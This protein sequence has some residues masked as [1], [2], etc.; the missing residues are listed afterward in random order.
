MRICFYCH[1]SDSNLLDL[2]EFYKLDIDALKKLDEKLVIATRYKDIDWSCDIL[3]IWWWSY[4]LY[5]ILRGRF[6]H[7]MK[8]V[9]TGTFN[10][11]TLNYS[12]DYFHRPLWQKVLLKMA[13][14]FSCMNIMVSKN[15]YDMM[16][17]DWKYDNFCYSPH[18]IDTNVY[19]FS[20]ENRNSDFVLMIS[21]LSVSNV[22]RKCVMEVIDAIDIIRNENVKCN[23][24]IAGIKGD[25]YE[26]VR[27][28]I[29][30]KGLDDYVELLGTISIEHK[31]ELLQSCRCYLQPTNFEGFGVAIAEAMSCGAPIISS[32]RGEV[33]N[34]LGN[35]G[36]LLESNTPQN[37]AN[38]IKT[39]FRGGLNSKQ[40]DAR[41]RIETLFS[42][43]RRYSD[44]KTI[45]QK[46]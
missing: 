12:R 15:E 14:K 2:V 44:I 38:A 1:L 7:S 3:F 26:L 46:M 43:Q 33:S 36:I 24:K 6:F 37:I 29:S 25:A 31:I 39:I 45:I 8:V 9:V 10:Y 4:A 11:N 22:K 40:Y 17:T 23:L 21:A 13:V 27:N 30:Y 35:A 18:C 32:N 19:K 16:R 5:P 41:K 20:I 28:Y 42:I 34:V